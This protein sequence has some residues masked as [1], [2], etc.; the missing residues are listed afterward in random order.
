MPESREITSLKERGWI[1]KKTINNKCDFSKDVLIEYGNNGLN[2]KDFC[3]KC[4]EQNRSQ[5]PIGERVVKY[6]HLF[7]N[8]EKYHF[9]IKKN[10][11]YNYFKC[12]ECGYKKVKIDTYKTSIK[13]L[14]IHSI[15]TL[16]IG[17]IIRMMDELR[18]SNRGKYL[19]ET[20]YARIEGEI[21]AYKDVLD[22]LGTPKYKD[23]KK[24][25]EELEK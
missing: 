20:Y 5:I 8:L 2:E 22:M 23:I 12:D 14:S 17:R 1:V 9:K 4:Y 15:R 18:P 25:K 10:T 6:K 16:L 3:P 21:I 11:L 24:V 19:L 7:T 13:R